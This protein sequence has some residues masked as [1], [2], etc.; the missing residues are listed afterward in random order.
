MRL[1]GWRGT[2][3]DR[4]VAIPI[5][6]SLAVLA[7]I[8]WIVTIWQTGSSTMMMDSGVPMSIDASGRLALDTAVYFLVIWLFMMAAMMFPSLWPVVLAYAATS[9][10]RPAASVPIFIA[11]YLLVWEIFG[12]A[13]YLFYVIVGAIAMGVPAVGMNLNIVAGVLAILAGLYQL[14]PM[15]AICLSA[16]QGRVSSLVADIRFGKSSP[17]GLGISHGRSCV[18]CCAGE[19]ILLVALGAMDLR[20][21]AAVALLIGVENSGRAPASCQSS[22]GSASLSRA[23][24]C[25]SPK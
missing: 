15:K 25:C 1:S 20:W 18:G 19:M 10:G 11:G 14:T 16:C 23:S 5:L 6:V 13:A 9:R 7:V 17:L 8:S 24:S 3:P 22:S 4:A 21:M 2:W 12:L